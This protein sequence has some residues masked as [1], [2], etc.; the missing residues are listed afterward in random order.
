MMT[1]VMMATRSDGSLGNGGG[2][3]GGNGGSTP[4]AGGYTVSD[5]GWSHPSHRRPTCP[6][7]WARWSG[8]LVPADASPSIASYLWAKI[9]TMPD[10]SSTPVSAR[11]RLRKGLKPGKLPC[12]SDLSITENQC[13]TPSRCGR[14]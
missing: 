7:N 6:W 14:S 9:I 13:Q 11:R 4:E 2:V 12:A 8:R 1:M 10:S 5:C 3:V